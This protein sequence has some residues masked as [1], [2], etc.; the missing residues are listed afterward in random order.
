MNWESWG[1]TR[2]VWITLHDANT[3]RLLH[4]RDSTWDSHLFPSMSVEKI[5]CVNAKRRVEKLRPAHATLYDVSPIISMH[6]RAR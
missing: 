3:V 6:A 5:L 1:Y 4:M 2:N